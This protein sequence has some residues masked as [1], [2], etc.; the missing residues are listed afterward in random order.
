MT[1][2]DTF[3]RS[4]S[5][6]LKYKDLFNRT[7]EE[8]DA[9]QAQKDIKALAKIN[10]AEKK[11]EITSEG[12][13]YL[14]MYYTDSMSVYRQMYSV[15]DSVFGEEENFKIVDPVTKKTILDEDEAHLKHVTPNTCAIFRIPFGKSKNPLFFTMPGVKNVDRAIEKIK[16]DGKYK[17]NHKKL[18]DVLRVS[19]SGKRLEEIE[20]VYQEFLKMPGIKIDE[21]ETK[22]KFCGNDVKRADEF[23]EKNFRNKVFFIHLPNGLKVE[24]QLKITALEMVD[25]LTHKMYEEQR[26]INESSSLSQREKETRTLNIDRSIGMLYRLG[27]EKYNQKVLEK[28]VRKESRYKAKISNKKPSK[29]GVYSDCIKIIQDNFLARPKQMLVETEPLFDLTPDLKRQ[30]GYEGLSTELKHL[31]RDASPEVKDVFNR[32]KKYI[33]PKYRGVLSQKDIEKDRSF[34]GKKTNEDVLVSV[35][36][37][38]R[39]LRR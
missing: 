6:P 17:G 22:D 29:D 13:D 8:I 36:D 34:H 3:D 31:F 24:V 16:I 14:R 35:L 23:T 4:V 27:I 20:N 12:A 19:I 10:R 30:I 5:F 1:R 38:K 15:F 32:Y 9:D 18:N 39:N 11:G 21:K 26:K 37:Q 2:K 7:D 28:V 25:D 33:L